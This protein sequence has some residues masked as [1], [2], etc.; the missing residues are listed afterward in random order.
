MNRKTPKPRVAS[1]K[2]M[3]TYS[4]GYGYAI[5]ITPLAIDEDGAKTT[6]F[7][8][9]EGS[10]LGK[11]CWADQA[12]LFDTPEQALAKLIA[13]ELPRKKA[14][15]GIVYPRVVKMQLKCDIKSVGNE[16]SASLFG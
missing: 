16:L 6:E 2:T 4:Y 15:D 13:S 12:M 11:T 14:S 3:Q 9:E 1:I 5:Q 8:A 10:G 7:I